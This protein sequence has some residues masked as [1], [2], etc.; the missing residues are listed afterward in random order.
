MNPSEWSKKFESILRS[1]DGL[2]FCMVQIPC[3]FSISMSFM[4]E[5]WQASHFYRFTAYW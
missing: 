4:L 1:F 3:C 5:I 2:W